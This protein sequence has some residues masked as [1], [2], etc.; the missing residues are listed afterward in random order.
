MI[1]RSKIKL[2]LY[3]T[4]VTLYVASSMEE[5]EDMVRKKTKNNN[6]SIKDTYGVVFGWGEAGYVIALH[7]E[8][9]SHNLIAHEVFHLAIMITNDIDIEDEES[10]AWL[11]GYL[12]EH[13]Y[14]ALKKK[15]L[16]IK[17]K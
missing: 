7:E 12:T 4:S 10:Q 9:L 6:L 3:E 13:V 16:V 17:E 2:E 1:I 15:K 5:F 8:N 14:K 11:V